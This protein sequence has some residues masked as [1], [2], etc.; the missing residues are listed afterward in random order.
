M[1]PSVSQNWPNWVALLSIILIAG[2]TFKGVL[3]KWY[4]G[5]RADQDRM[6]AFCDRTADIVDRFS[7]TI[8]ENQTAIMAL[9]KD[10]SSASDDKIINAIREMSTA[11]NEATGRVLLALGKR[12][13]NTI[14]AIEALA[15]AIRDDLAAL[16]APPPPAGGTGSQVRDGGTTP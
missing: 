16:R 7:R 2:R 14:L 15:R 8:L 11:S 12:E 6:H 5:M 13:E 4:R 1:M 3:E 9:V 10:T